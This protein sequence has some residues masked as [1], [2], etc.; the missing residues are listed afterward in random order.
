[1]LECVCFLVR[2]MRQYLC[3]C[4][5]QLFVCSCPCVNEHPA[6]LRSCI[7][8]TL[9]C[10]INGVVKTKILVY[11]SNKKTCHVERIDLCGDHTQD[12]LRVIK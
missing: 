9:T 12:L 8:D 3:A 6:I 2:L 11:E 5:H 7:V 4:Q 1:M 10:C